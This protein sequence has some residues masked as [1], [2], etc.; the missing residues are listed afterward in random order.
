MLKVLRWILDF[1]CLL[2][3]LAERSWAVADRTE[4]EAHEQYDEIVKQMCKHPRYLWLSQLDWKFSVIAVQ[5]QSRSKRE[6]FIERGV[7][8]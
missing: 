2:Q 4:R 5:F 7:H 6:A 1:F 3:I 8:C